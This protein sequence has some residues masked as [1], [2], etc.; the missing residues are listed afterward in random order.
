MRPFSAS[1]ALA[2]SLHARAKSKLKLELHAKSKLKL[3]LHTKAWKKAAGP[4]HHCTIVI[5]ELQQQLFFFQR[6]NQKPD[7]S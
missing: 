6:Y 5:T 7:Q 1:S 4:A 2:C 3:E